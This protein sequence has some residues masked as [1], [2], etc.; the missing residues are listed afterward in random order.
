VAPHVRVG[1]SWWNYRFRS[2][3]NTSCETDIHATS[4]SYKQS[5]FDLTFSD[6]FQ[7]T[8]TSGIGKIERQKTTPFRTSSNCNAVRQLYEVKQ[9]SRKSAAQSECRRSQ[10]SSG[11]PGI[12]AKNRRLRRRKT[13]FY[14]QEN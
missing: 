6:W 7:E 2:G 5:Q 13:H 9:L 14:K 1:S 10:N 12:N 11:R 4:R 8:G 3:H